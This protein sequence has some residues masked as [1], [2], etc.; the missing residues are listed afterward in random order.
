MNGKAE[1]ATTDITALGPVTGDTSAVESVNREPPEAND[2]L[3]GQ[4]SKGLGWSVV[5]TVV[6]RLG[7][8]VAGIAL[9]RILEPRD[10]G[11]F[12]VALVVL[13]ALLSMNELG[14]SLAIVRWPGNVASIAPTVATLALVSSGFLYLLTFAAAPAI[15]SALSSPES[16]NMIRLLAVCVLVDAVSAVS[17]GQI[18]REFMQRR[19]L[20]IDVS[21][22]IVGT[23][24]TILLA[25]LGYGG[26]SLLWGFVAT[27][28]VTGVM[29]IVLAPKW[30]GYGF[31][32]RE[33]RELLE[34][35]IPL[36]GSSAVLYLLMNLDYI[37][38]G[39]L[40]DPTA[41]GLYLLAF[42]ICSWPVNLV[43][44]AIRRVTVAGFSRFAER[45]GSIGD[46]FVTPASLVVAL[47]LPMAVALIVFTE[48]LI[49]T[50]YGVKWIG[51]VAAL[52]FLAVLAVARV[53]IELVYDFLVA[54]NRNRANLLLQCIWLVATAPA[55][56]FGAKLLGIEGVALGHASVALLI[57]G[58]AAMWT[59]RRCGVPLRPLLRSVARPLTGAVAMAAAALLTLRFVEG[60]WQEL[61][62]G[63]AVAGAVYLGVVW[64]MARKTL[65]AL[66]DWQSVD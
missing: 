27:N 33:A 47:T 30:Y 23:I 35:G 12:A 21:G 8:L 16:T 48:P 43:S 31:D 55:L 2:H 22:F 26:W 44:T 7:S 5:N 1:R 39:R 13:V 59:L 54:V 49:T 20:M 15:A 37:V 46:G 28:V 6:S 51:A 40:L 38:V 45:D 29:A 24:L 56:V 10:Y 63:S 50:V 61:L 60:E 53:M 25:I 41:L 18:T 34:F 32:R 42:N 19:R 17:A 3:M 14:V 52:R 36:A 66:T 4:V 62:V 11:T 57:L 9:A 64:P 58:P 65:R